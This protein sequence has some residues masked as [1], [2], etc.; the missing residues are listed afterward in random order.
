M[1]RT[2]DSILVQLT[3]E[4][5]IEIR[6]PG[7][8]NHIL[9]RMSQG[10]ASSLSHALKLAAEGESQVMTVTAEGVGIGEAVKA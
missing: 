5:N 1:I 2:T 6:D 8:E 4:F 3:A 10:E 7:N 9:L